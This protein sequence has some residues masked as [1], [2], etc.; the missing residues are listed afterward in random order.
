MFSRHRQEKPL[1][2]DYKST[3]VMT[4]GQTWCLRPDLR[5]SPQTTSL[6]ETGTDNI[7]NFLQA[8]PQA[9]LGGGALRHPRA[10]P[11]RPWKAL[12]TS[13]CGRDA[14]SRSPTIDSDAG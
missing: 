13:H 4:N 2:V 3:D 14:R 7:R 8:W 9:F 11:S 6:P 5:I 10:L 12:P 1:L